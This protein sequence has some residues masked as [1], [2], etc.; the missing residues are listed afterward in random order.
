MG[1]RGRWEHKGI[2]RKETKGS[3]EAFNFFRRVISL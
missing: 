1:G 3:R 2:W